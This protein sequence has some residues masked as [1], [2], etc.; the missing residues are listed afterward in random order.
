MRAVVQRVTSA[1][2]FVDN[3]SC[4][5]IGAGLLVFLGV[6]ADDNQTDLSWLIAR[7][8]KLRIF[9]DE[10][11][12]MNLSLRDT[13]AETMVVS[14][15]TVF[16]SLKKGNRPSFNRAALP[17]PAELLY[18]QF[19]ERFAQES[20]STVASGRFGRHMVIEAINDGPVTLI[21]DSKNRDF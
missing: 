1:K 20:G 13:N 21:V 5:S 16:G 18:E 11:G 15:F 7:L 9:D 17:A 19:L 3:E 10:S 2:V 6:A 12:L 4:G 8:I 14:Q